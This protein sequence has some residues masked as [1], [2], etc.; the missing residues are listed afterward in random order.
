[1][2]FKEGVLREQKDLISHIEPVG[3]ADTLWGKL[4]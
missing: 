1:M 2:K 3:K 4:T